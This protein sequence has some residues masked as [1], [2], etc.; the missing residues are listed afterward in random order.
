MSANAAH[1]LQ[2]AVGKMDEII[3]EDDGED[4][5]LQARGRTGSGSGENDAEA[6]SRDREGGGR[7]CL[8]H[9]HG[10]RRQSDEAMCA[11]PFIARL[12]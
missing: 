10:M 1:V 9:R 3:P 6:A 8:L 5:A 7:G 4:E 11:G 12:A 2:L